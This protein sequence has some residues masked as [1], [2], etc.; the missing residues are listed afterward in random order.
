M[1]VNKDPLGSKLKKT[2]LDYCMGEDNEESYR[3]DLSKMLDEWLEE[4]IR[5]SLV[6]F[7]NF[8]LDS[9]RPSRILKHVSH[10][11]IENWEENKKAVI[12]LAE[13]EDLVKRLIG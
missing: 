6:S 11:D 9:R 13:D 12:K 1:R 7:G 3:D 4:V 8:L 10:A 5:Y 2:I